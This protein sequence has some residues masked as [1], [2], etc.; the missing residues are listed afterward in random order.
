MRRV[1]RM[2]PSRRTSR[3]AISLLLVFLQRSKCSLM[4]VEFSA[5]HPV[6]PSH[7]RSPQA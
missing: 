2:S 1:L 4:L 5:L 7:G 6:T 3:A